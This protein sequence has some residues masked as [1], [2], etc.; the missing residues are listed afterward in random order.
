MVGKTKSK[1][2]ISGSTTGTAVDPASIDAPAST[3]QTPVQ[4][5]QQSPADPFIADQ[6]LSGLQTHSFKY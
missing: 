5:I 4:P 6:G 1:K 3:H 2:D